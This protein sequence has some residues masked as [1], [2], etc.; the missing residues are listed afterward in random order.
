MPSCVMCDVYIPSKNAMCC[1]CWTNTLSSQKGMC[2]YAKI[3]KNDS[4]NR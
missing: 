2:N 1:T 3:Q 4:K